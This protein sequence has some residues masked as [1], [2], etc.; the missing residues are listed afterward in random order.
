MYCFRYKEKMCVYLK[1]K[2]RCCCCCYILIS[3]AAKAGKDSANMCMYVCMCVCPW[4]PVRRRFDYLNKSVYYFFEI[5]ENVS[6]VLISLILLMICWIRSLYKCSFSSVLFGFK[7]LCARVCV[8]IVSHKKPPTK[9]Y[10][11]DKNLSFFIYH[12]CWF[13][14]AMANLFLA[15][16]HKVLVVPS[17]TIFGNCSTQ[18]GKEVINKQ[19]AFSKMKTA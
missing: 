15:L 11:C 17:N 9:A 12:S 10:V 19:A 1:S 2:I 13:P 18:N 16:Y 6:F 8:M 14:W 5:F 3:L 7:S 4:S